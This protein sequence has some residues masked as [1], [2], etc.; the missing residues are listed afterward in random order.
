MAGEL[1]WVRSLFGPRAAERGILLDAAAAADLPPELWLD[2][3]RFRQIVTNL[4]GNA[5]KFT[6]P[7]GQV[8]VRLERAENSTGS[9]LVLEV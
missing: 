9:D 3:G 6:P 7:G 8:R 4:T 1:D 2:E 5:L